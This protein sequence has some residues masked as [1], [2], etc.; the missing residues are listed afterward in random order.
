MARLQ[1]GRAY[2]TTPS[3]LQTPRPI[4]KINSENYSETELVFDKPQEHAHLRAS[5]TAIAHNLNIHPS[6][7]GQNLGPP[8]Q[9]KNSEK[10]RGVRASVSWG[11]TLNIRF[12]IIEGNKNLDF[13]QPLLIHTETKLPTP[14]VY[15]MLS[16]LAIDTSKRELLYSTHWT[17]PVPTNDK[18]LIN[19]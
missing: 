1:S 9:A 10:D 11:D 13:E 18:I 17:H 16:A 3:A 8:G 6:P 4:L 5:R 2:S 15:L 19:V 12:N 7:P 14:N